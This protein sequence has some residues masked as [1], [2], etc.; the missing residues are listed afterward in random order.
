MPDPAP[1]V[2]VSGHRLDDTNASLFA[3]RLLKPFEIEELVAVVM[4]AGRA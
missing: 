3:A 1:I 4:R 2:A